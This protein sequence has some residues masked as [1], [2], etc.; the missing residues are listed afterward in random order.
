[1]IER[2]TNMSLE[3]Y[4]QEHILQPLSIKNITFHLPT[5]PDMATLLL[6]MSHRI[7]GLSPFGTPL[8]P[9]AKLEP[10]VNPWWPADVL[11]DAGGGG[12]YAPITD[13]Q[14]ILHSITASDEKLLSTEMN[15]ELFRPQLGA[16]SRA[17]LMEALKIGESGALSAPGLP[18][19]TEVDYAL[20]GMVVLQDVEGRRRSGSMHWEGI[21]NVFWWADRK[22]GICGVYGSQVLGIG[23]PKSIERFKD[24]EKTMYERAKAA[25]VE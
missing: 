12:A 17:H 22:E 25:K 2:T 9:E 14:K 11:G 4:M 15:D 24:F 18:M 3:T 8:T 13:V 7:G 21:P 6:P 5:R 19:G 16:V 23:D 10:G 1:M 20:G